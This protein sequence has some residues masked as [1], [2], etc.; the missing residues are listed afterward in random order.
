MPG[1]IDK[2]RMNGTNS[3][4]VT[5]FNEDCYGLFIDIN[6]AL[7]CSSRYIH[8]V[9]STSLNDNNNTFIIV[10]GNTTSGSTSIQLSQ[11]WG[12][13]VNTD[14]KLY[15]ADAGNSR[16]QRFQLGQQNGITVAGNGIPNN[17]FL[18][19][20]TDVILDADDYL[21]IADDGNYRIIRAGTSNYSCVAGC[22]GSNGSAPNQFHN[23]YS[24]RFDSRGNM[25]V[26][27]EYNYRIQKFKLATNSCGEFD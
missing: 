21:F 20:P 4:F 19:F 17:L 18:N 11:P 23:A 6:N 14:L 13:F 24:L 16:I 27:D 25:Y 7:Y 15:V 3:E 5:T 1:R 2:W 9:A 26:A 12:I 8:Q 10:A 22:S